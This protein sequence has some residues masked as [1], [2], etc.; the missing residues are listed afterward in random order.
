MTFPTEKDFAS[1]H[2]GLDIFEQMTASETVMKTISE[3]KEMVRTRKAD[4]IT[5]C[6]S[7]N[8]I[9]K[10]IRDSLLE[11]EVSPNFADERSRPLRDV[12]W[13]FVKQFQVATFLGAIPYFKQVFRL[14]PFSFWSFVLL[15]FDAFVTPRL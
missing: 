3:F 7:A 5:F 14:P 1:G 9:W 2:L 8:G 13:L 15:H 6:G 12:A 10:Y 4:L 11:F